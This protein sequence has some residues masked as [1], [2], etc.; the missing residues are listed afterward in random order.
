MLLFISSLQLCCCVF[1]P[2]TL[3]LRP[4]LYQLFPLS[5]I[6]FTDPLLF[7]CTDLLQFD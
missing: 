4:L 2:S 5:L 1:N 3:L 7:A 6:L